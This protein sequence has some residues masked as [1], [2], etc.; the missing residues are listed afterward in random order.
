MGE[1]IVL[2]G[3]TSSRYTDEETFLVQKLVRATFGNNNVDTCARVCHSPTGYGLKQTLGESAGTQTFDSVMKSDVIMIIGANPASA[4]PVFAS[5]MKRRLRQGARLIV[6]DPRT[7]EM[8]KSPHIQA[9]YHLKLMPGTN[10]A[11]VNA[12]AHVIVTENLHRQD[13][14]AERCDVASFEEWKEFVSL[15]ENSPEAVEAATGV[16][17]ADIRGAA[18]L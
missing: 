1:S 5:Q 14:I 3:I 13:F 16:P 10:V 18:R 6:I 7:T 15:P 12:L 9:D 4:H 2:G 8:V 11:I 17:A